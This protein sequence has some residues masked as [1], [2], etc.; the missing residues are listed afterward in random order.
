MTGPVVQ[1]VKFSRPDGDVYYRR[2]GSGEPVVF[3]HAAPQA[4]WSFDPVLPLFSQKF[5]CYVIDLPGFDHSDTPPRKY[6][7]DDFTDAVADMMDHAG[8]T[9]AH[10][11]GSHT[12]AVVGMNLAARIPDRVRKLVV[13]DSP[14]WN[15]DEGKT[16][17]EKFFRPGYDENDLPRPTP[18]EAALARNP[19][20]DREKHRRQNEVVA[21]DPA[22]IRVCHQANTSFDVQAIMG[23]VKVPTLVIFE[24][25]DPLRR[26]E[27]RFVEEIEGARLVVIPG[28]NDEAHYHK[29]QEFAREVIPFLEG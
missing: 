17:F 10:I 27:Q 11:V 15:L 1:E 2:A 4:G 5:T 16:I 22:W 12:G 21:A 3:L 8:L 20:L 13:E 14:G 24:E 18:L 7:I 19:N 9:Q 26:R 23:R 25:N 6:T 29:P 28:D